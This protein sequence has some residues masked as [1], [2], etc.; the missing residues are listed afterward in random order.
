MKLFE[1]NSTI[2]VHLGNS[3]L[4]PF[5]NGQVYLS[6]IPLA[7]LNAGQQQRG[8]HGLA[9][10]GRA[11]TYIVE[12]ATENVTT[13]GSLADIKVVKGFSSDIF[14]GAVVE[15]AGLSLNDLKGLP[16]VVNVWPNDQVNPKPSAQE[17]NC[18]IRAERPRDFGH[19]ITGV[20]KLHERGIFGKGVKIGVVDTGI[21]YKHDALGGGFGKGFKVAGGYDF[22]GNGG[23]PS[24]GHEKQPGGDPLDLLGYGTSVA[25]IIAGKTNDFLGVAPDATLYAYKVMGSQGSTQTST[26][27]E[28]FLAAYND[29]VDIITA[30]IGAPSGWAEEAWAVVASRMVNKGIVVTT[31]AGNLGFDGPFGMKTAASGKNVLAVAMANTP[32]A[33]GTRA[34]S[35]TSWGLLNDLGLKPDVAAPGDS[36]NTT[37]LDNGWVVTGGTSMSCPYVAGIAALYIGEFGGRH[38]HGDRFALDLSR[39]IVSTARRLAYH[40]SEYADLA[41]PVAQVGNG[42]V[43]AVKLFD[44]TTALEFEPIALN[45][46][47]HF[48]GRHEIIVK[49]FAPVDVRYHLS[50]QDAYGVDTLQLNCTDGSKTV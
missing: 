38:V 39:R 44:S 42:L 34:S 13:L 33:D 16:G 18:K 22:V 45:D 35:I 50:S 28:A 1:L 14:T 5:Q 9:A 20:S 47:R 31:S 29:G 32:S 6:V 25:G 48:N 49:N 15:T 23:W 10:T 27:I 21:W 19:N 46:T 41:A 17:Q 43:D 40:D 7:V 11:K 12:Y 24:A 26:L 4:A 37:A 2:S 3:K 8:E 30:S 36:V